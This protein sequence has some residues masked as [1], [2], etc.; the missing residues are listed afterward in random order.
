MAFKAGDAV[1][2]ITRHILVF[3]VHFRLQ[4]AN[5]AT[6]DGIIS[7]VGMAISTSIPFAFVFARINRKILCIVI[8]IGGLP[9]ILVMTKLAIR[10]KL[11]RLVIGIGGGVVIALMAAKAGRWRILVVSVVANHAIISDKGMGTLKRVK[12]IVNG[13]QRRL[14]VRIGG[15]AKLALVR[16]SQ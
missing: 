15:M 3:I 6:E 16:K 12:I 13:E 1:V 5:G 2:H 11:R 14:P 4:M 9:G 8:E 10:G 7:G